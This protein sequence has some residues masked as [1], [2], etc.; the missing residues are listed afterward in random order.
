MFSAAYEM[1]GGEKRK[2]HSVSESLKIIRQGLPVGML[3]RG[4]LVLGLTKTE[5]AKI[6]GVNLRTLQRKMK[7]PNATLSPTA[8]EHALMLTDIVIEADEYFGD[9]DATLRWLNKPSLVFDKETPLSLCDTITGIILVT[10]E[11]NKLKYGYTA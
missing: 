3:D 10:E 7:E 1:L 4:M 2:A 8:S 9:R 5:Y 11:I 6:I